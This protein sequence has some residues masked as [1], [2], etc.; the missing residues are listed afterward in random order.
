MIP[1]IDLQE[2]AEWHHIDRETYM[3]KIIFKS[4]EMIITKVGMGWRRGMV[5]NGERKGVIAEVQV[6]MIIV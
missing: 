4:K 2:R 6:R 1:I 3:Y 5:L